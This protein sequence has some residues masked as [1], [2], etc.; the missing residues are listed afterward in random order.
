MHLLQEDLS[1]LEQ[2][3]NLSRITTAVDTAEHCRTISECLANDH[4]ATRKMRKG[5][6]KRV[7]I[8]LFEK[9]PKQ[10]G[11]EIGLFQAALYLAL[12]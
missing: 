4:A 1:Q 5:G 3:R 9:E 12:C 6:K 11:K 10:S 2:E 8:I 7:V